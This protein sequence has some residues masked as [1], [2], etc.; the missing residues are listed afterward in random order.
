MYMKNIFAIACTVILFMACNKENENVMAPPSNISFGTMTD[1]R[2]GNEYK[3]ITIGNQEWMA[4]NLRYRIPNGSLGGCY[5]FGEVLINPAQLQVDKP[6]FKDSVNKAIANGEIVDPPGLPEA[7]RPIYII[8]RY[9]NLY[10]VSQLMD[11]LIPYPD[12]TKVLNRI[13]ENL[14]VPAA[15]K[16]AAINLT[17]AESSNGNYSKIYGLLYTYDAAMNAAPDGW[18]I[19]TDED[20]MELE[21]TM[22]MPVSSLNQLEQWRGNVS[23]RFI[24]NSDNSV[25]FNA[26]LGG[27]KLYGVFMYGTSFLNKEVNGYYWSSSEYKANDSTTFGITRNFMMKRNGVWRGTTKKES[28]YHIK[29]IKIK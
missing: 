13:N 23:N 7:Q 24:A 21:K 9:I 17:Q 11:R 25:G 20:W 22:G 5:T 15:V 28:A 2:D 18:R 3:T 26:L 29:C 4:E 6:M 19:P 27:G 12:V 16:Q 14:K 1:E 10:T 8:N